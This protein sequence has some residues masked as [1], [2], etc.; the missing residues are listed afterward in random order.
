MCHT[1]FVIISRCATLHDLSPLLHSLALYSNIIKKKSCFLLLQRKRVV[2]WRE[3]LDIY[4][5]TPVHHSKL[6]CYPHKKSSRVDVDPFITLTRNPIGSWALALFEC[7]ID[8]VNDMNESSLLLASAAA[9]FL[10]LNWA[11]ISIPI[12]YVYKLAEHSSFKCGKHLQRARDVNCKR[13]TATWP[14]IAHNSLSCLGSSIVASSSEAREMFGMLSTLQQQQQHR[15]LQLC[16]H[17]WRADCARRWSNSVDNTQPSSG[18]GLESFYIFLFFI[19]SS[20]V[21][22]SEEIAIWSNMIDDL[23]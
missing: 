1:Q 18:A 8:G 20:R 14:F 10:S 16:A 6:Q 23:N 2:K 4:F 9:Y 12:D 19:F 22:S 11:V 21:F 17:E 7:I 13:L 15:E 3:R 5:F